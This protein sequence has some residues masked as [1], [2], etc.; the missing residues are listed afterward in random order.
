M[1][2]RRYSVYGYVSTAVLLYT[3]ENNIHREHN[4][5]VP[6]SKQYIPKLDI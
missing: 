1:N 6:K 5:C 3:A 2:K 4:H